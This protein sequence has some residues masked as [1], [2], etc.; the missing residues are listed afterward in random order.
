MA[1]NLLN[2]LS[3]NFIINTRDR[4]GKMSGTRRMIF[5][6][7]VLGTHPVP[8]VTFPGRCLASY[9][10]FPSISDY[11]QQLIIVDFELR[12]NELIDY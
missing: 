1:P 2:D 3:G 6:N 11:K 12:K 9:F 10:P 5:K 8:A 4:W 7:Y